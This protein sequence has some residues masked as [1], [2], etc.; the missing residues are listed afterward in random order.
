MCRGFGVFTVR[1]DD[2]SIEK[3][4]P[5]S[6][7]QSLVLIDHKNNDNNENFINRNE[8]EITNQKKKKSLKKLTKRQLSYE[9]ATNQVIKDNIS[10]VSYI[11]LFSFSF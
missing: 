5:R 6:R 2:G 4:I 7:L 9:K 10:N 1:A 8:N 3:N 11:S